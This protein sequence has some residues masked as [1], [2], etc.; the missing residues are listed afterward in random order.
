M[1]SMETYCFLTSWYFHVV[2][3]KTTLRPEVHMTGVHIKKAKRK[4]Q[5]PVWQ[6]ILVEKS[7]QQDIKECPKP[8][9]EKK[10]SVKTLLSTSML[11]FFNQII[12]NY[13]FSHIGKNNVSE[14]DSVSISDLTIFYTNLFQ[15]PI[16]SAS[17]Q[18]AKFKEVTIPFANTMLEAGRAIVSRA[19]SADPMDVLLSIS[20]RNKSQKIFY[21]CEQTIAS[22]IIFAQDYPRFPALYV[23]P[24]KYGSLDILQNV[25]LI[26]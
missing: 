10:N 7:F 22:F 16:F 20:I 14:W 19:D 1:C 8:R 18:T 11:F 4:L 9:T 26:H 5:E 24:R 6:E 15:F 17:V 25:T 12:A 2:F 3:I 23:S 13:R 21:S